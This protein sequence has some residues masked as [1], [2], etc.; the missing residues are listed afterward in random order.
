MGFTMKLKR[1]SKI[2]KDG[3]RTIRLYCTHHDAN[4]TKE[5]IEIIESESGLMEESCFFGL[6]FKFLPTN[7]VWVLYDIYERDKMYH[8]HPFFYNYSF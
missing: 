6:T 8:S 7:S 3:S 1:P 2:N 4:Y 5:D